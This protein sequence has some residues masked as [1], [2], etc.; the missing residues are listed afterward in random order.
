MKLE[1]NKNTLKSDTFVL[2]L[3]LERKHAKN[4]KIILHLVSDGV[5]SIPLSSLY[6]L[7][8]YS[9]SMSLD[10]NLQSILNDS[11]IFN[12]IKRLR[13]IPCVLQSVVAC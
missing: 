8:V 1:N 7:P 9:L 10:W 6:F 4:F 2:I 3:D 12:S 5:I 13:V 11:L